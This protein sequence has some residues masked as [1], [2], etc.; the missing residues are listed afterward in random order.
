MNNPLYTKSFIGPAVIAACALSCGCT[1]AL[2]ADHE[3][4][5]TQAVPATN[6]DLNVPV[7][8]AGK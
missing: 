2:A 6:L 4:V 3:V 8:V 5:A 1:P 7:Q